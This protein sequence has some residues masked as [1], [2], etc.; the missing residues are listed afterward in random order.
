VEGDSD[1]SD[2]DSDDSDDDDAMADAI[3]ASQAASQAESERIA[4]ER[5]T[6]KHPFKKRRKAAAAAARAKRKAEKKCEIEARRT[7]KAKRAA[8]KKAEKKRKV[9][10]RRAAKVKREAE[11]KRKIEVRKAKESARKA[12]KA[13]KAAKAGLKNVLDNPPSGKDAREAPQ[14]GAV[15]LRWYRRPRVG[16]RR[17]LPLT[18]LVALLQIVEDDGACLAME[19]AVGEGRLEA[20]YPTVLVPLAPLVTNRIHAGANCR[21]GGSD[22]VRGH[23]RASRSGLASRVYEG[24]VTVGVNGWIQITTLG[25]PSYLQHTAV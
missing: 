22:A 18:L 16:A 10:A 7:A 13:A 20:H 4:E 14:L 24:V 23:V 17:V 1:D 12:A 15:V 11:K 5:A 8:D 3:R 2:S 21:G 6:K 19:V 25:V 9:E